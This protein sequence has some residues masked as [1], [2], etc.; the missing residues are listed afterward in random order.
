M[1]DFSKRFKLCT[2]A[3][4]E[5]KFRKQEFYKIVKGKQVAV[6]D[7]KN[8]AIPLIYIWMLFTYKCKSEEVEMGRYMPPIDDIGAGLDAEWIALNLNHGN[9]FD[10]EYTPNEGDNLFITQNQIMAPYISFIYTNA[11]WVTDNYDPF[12]TV[13]DLVQSGKLT[14]GE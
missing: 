4:G 9:C 14:A 7:K 3:V 11:Q 5:I 12:M 10:F 1:C 13:T 2:C 6:R 8:E